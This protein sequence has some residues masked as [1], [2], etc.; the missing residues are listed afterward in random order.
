[1]WVITPEVCVSVVAKDPTGEGRLCVRARTRGDLERLRRRYC[2][3]LTLA[4]KD[5]GTDY[6]WRA[7]CTPEEWAEAAARLALAVDYPNMKDRVTNDHRHDVYLDVWVALRR[8]ARPR[9]RR[10]P[11]YAYDENLDPFLIDRGAPL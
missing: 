10:R 8:L 3:Q 4:V 2:P 9:D 1:M 6:E 5:A 7:Y 11:R